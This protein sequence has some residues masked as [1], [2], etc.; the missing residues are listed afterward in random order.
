MYNIKK[1]SAYKRV[2]SSEFRVMPSED[3]DP[4]RNLQPVTRNPQLTTRNSQLTSPT[5]HV[6]T[7]YGLIR[8]N[9]LLVSAMDGKLVEV[10]FYQDKKVAD[11]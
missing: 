3:G 2:R 8:N 4:T 7:H 6:S 1:S 10:N 11:E 5:H 9:L